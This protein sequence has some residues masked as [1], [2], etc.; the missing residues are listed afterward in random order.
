MFVPSWNVIEN[1]KKKIEAHSRI[2]TARV[3]SFKIITFGAQM[4]FPTVW[5]L[6]SLE[7][8]L[9]A[10]SYS[11]SFLIHT[12]P[13]ISLALPSLIMYFFTRPDSWSTF[14]CFQNN[15]SPFYYKFDYKNLNVKQSKLGMVGK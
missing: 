1:L 3:S 13:L 15:H 6:L 9:E 10:D 12:I 11:A 5:L 8:Y 7:P 4:C 14:I 2:Y